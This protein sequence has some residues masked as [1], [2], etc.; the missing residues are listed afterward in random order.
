MEHQER[1][2][3]IIKMPHFIIKAIQE[4]FPELEKQMRLNPNQ[5]TNILGS[6]LSVVPLQSTPVMS[7]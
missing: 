2:F 6:F 1:D 4:A 7:E 5:A 3:A